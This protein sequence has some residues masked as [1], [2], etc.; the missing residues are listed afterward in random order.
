MAEAW[1]R[2]SCLTARTRKVGQDRL[3]LLKLFPGPAEREPDG[4]VVLYIHGYPI[5]LGTPLLTKGRNSSRCWKQAEMVMD[6]F[7]GIP[8][9]R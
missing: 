6:R 7:T 2:N 1:K 8:S 9:L 4:P 3:V 5:L